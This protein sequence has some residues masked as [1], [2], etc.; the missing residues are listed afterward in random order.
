MTGFWLNLMKS[1]LSLGELRRF[2]RLLETR[3]FAF[4]DARVPRQETG[5]FQG[6]LV[7]FRI[8]VNQAREIP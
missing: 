3:L 4:L 8:G 7:L 1:G 2:S 6:G 5:L